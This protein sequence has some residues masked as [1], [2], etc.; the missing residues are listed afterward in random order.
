MKQNKLLDKTFWKFI[1]VGVINTL[2]G[3]SVMFLS[4]NLLKFSYWV[5][6]ALNYILGSILSYFL[7]KNFT[8]RNREKGWRVIARF[9]LNISVC[10]LLAYGLAK[11]LVLWFLSG[12]AIRM[13][14][15]I[16]ELTGMGPVKIQENIAML[17]GMCLFVVLNYVGQ[18]LFA[19]APR[20]EGERDGQRPS[21]EE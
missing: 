20:K 8:F 4:Y 17:V 2:F 12:H 9:V 11:P 6:S 13:Q 16:A 1:L 21:S 18:R 19:F 5:S 14:E 10:Y 15:S 3:T 7:N